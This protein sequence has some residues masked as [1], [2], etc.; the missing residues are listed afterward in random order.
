MNYL[1][2][3]PPPVFPLPHPEVVG[4]DLSH[5]RAE[6]DPG[7]L[8]AE[9]TQRPWSSA[10]CLRWNFAAGQ[11][12]AQVAVIELDQ[13]KGT[14][15]HRFAGAITEAEPPV[16]HAPRAQLADVSSPLF[17]KSSAA[18]AALNSKF[19]GENYSIKHDCAIYRKL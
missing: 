2:F 13:V 6:N 14:E 9:S 11:T 1:A 19:V 16:A 3:T 12:A 4:C 17:S 7:S 5:I 10:A 18:H 8:S 15:G